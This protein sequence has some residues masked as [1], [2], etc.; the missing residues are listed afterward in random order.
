VVAGNPA[1]GPNW[2]QPRRFT[3]VNVQVEIIVDD[4]SVG[5]ARYGPAQY[6]SEAWIGYNGHMYYTR[7]NQ[8]TVTNYG[9]WQP[10]L[11]GGGAGTYAVSVYVPNNFADT[12][13]AV[14]TIFHN[15][16]TDARTINQAIRFNEWVQLGSFFFS[17]SGNEY[18]RLT[19]QTGEPGLSKRIGFDAVKWVKQ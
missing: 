19:D 1:A 8:N 15:G 9:I 7:N 12:T 3:T 13:N 6:W 16:T 17:A 10:N 4:Q 5:F 2:S 11:S 14:Y 18:V